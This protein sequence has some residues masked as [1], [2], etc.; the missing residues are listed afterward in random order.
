MNNIKNTISGL[1]LQVPDIAGLM[2]FYQSAFGMHT[3][4]SDKQSLSVGFPDG[5]CQLVFHKADVP[6]F[7]ERQNNF[8]WKTGVTVKDLD[9]AVQFLDGAGIEVTRPHQFRDIGYLCHLKD[10]SG[11]TIELLQCGFK[12][13]EQSV[14]HGHP[15]GAQANFA[16]ITLRVTDIVAAQ[17]YFTQLGMRLMSVQP[18][19]DYGFCLY[20][21][22][23]TDETL[24][25]PVLES[26]ENREWL[27]ARPYT[28]IELQHLQS[29][30]ATIHW[31][32]T[33]EAGIGGFSYRDTALADTALADTAL[34]DTFVA[35]KDIQ[36]RI[37]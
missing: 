31:Q 29:T 8:Y 28:L 35:T 15:I 34:A 19:A 18:V 26:V 4:H 13:R 25:N 11:F 14:P 5:T 27:W 2:D 20:F 23:W 9:K 6:A 21:Y 10:P 7:T 16:H 1:H 17:H 22:G 36:Q 30:N 37:C 24:P 12:G 32:T 3:V 33:T